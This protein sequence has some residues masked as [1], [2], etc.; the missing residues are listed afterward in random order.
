M[1]N[2]SKIREL[3]SVLDDLTA[4]IPSIEDKMKAIGFVSEIIDL[5]LHRVDQAAVELMEELS[6]G[7][8]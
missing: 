2:P 4:L 8:K 3:N 1:T 7:S 6:N 5:S